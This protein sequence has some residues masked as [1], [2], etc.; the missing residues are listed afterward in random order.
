MFHILFMQALQDALYLVLLVGTQ[1]LI[2]R[3]K[4][5]IQRSNPYSFYVSVDNH[6]IRSILFFNSTVTPDHIS[7]P[8]GYSGGSGCGGGLQ[9]GGEYAFTHFCKVKW[10]YI[11][12]SISICGW[13]LPLWVW[14]WREKMGCALLLGERLGHSV[15]S[16]ASYWGKLGTVS[17]FTL[18]RLWSSVPLQYK[19]LIHRCSSSVQS[20]CLMTID[21][22]NVA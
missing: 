15:I 4:E 5:C 21:T 9:R 16:G 6:L 8:T 20:H 3:A 18:G 1:W 11:K 14:Q 19:A 12:S 17:H 7:H 2:P 22:I 10:H 13:L